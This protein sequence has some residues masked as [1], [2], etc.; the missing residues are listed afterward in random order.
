METPNTLSPPHTHTHI[1]WMKPEE[2]QPEGREEA[3]V[4]LE[5]LNEVVLNT[6]LCEF[7]CVF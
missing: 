2:I 3:P 5:D 4:S 6:D 7:F 1:P